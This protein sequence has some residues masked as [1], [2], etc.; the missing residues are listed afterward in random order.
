[1]AEE[2][3]QVGGVC[4]VDRSFLPSAEGDLQGDAG[5]GEVGVHAIGDQAEGVAHFQRR[6]RA[7]QPNAGR[8]D[9]A[10]SAATGR[11]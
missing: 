4:L 3:A 1:M 6:L 9:G 7:G 10:G 11:R 2:P 8:E 5:A